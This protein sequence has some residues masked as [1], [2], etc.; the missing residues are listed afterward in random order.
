MRLHLRFPESDEDRELRIL[1]EKLE[2]IVERFRHLAVKV[3]G[4]KYRFALRDKQGEMG[5]AKTLEIIL[6]GD[7]RWNGILEVHFL[8]LFYSL[9]HSDVATSPRAQAISC[10]PVSASRRDGGGPVNEER[11]KVLE[12]PLHLTLT[13]TLS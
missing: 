7:T 1:S 4:S 10:C 5:A 12:G 9:Y 11:Q 3:R 13:L 6:P 2:I 8:H